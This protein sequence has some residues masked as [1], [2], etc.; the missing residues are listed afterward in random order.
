MAKHSVLKQVI[1][2]FFLL[3]FGA[4]C[5]I[6]QSSNSELMLFRKIIGA[7][8]LLNNENDSITAIDLI[9]NQDSI[10]LEMLMILNDTSNLNHLTI[11]I[12]SIQ[13]QSIVL[14]DT[15]LFNE[16]VFDF[17][18]TNNTLYFIKDLGKVINTHEL[19]CTVLIYNA[20]NQVT[21][22]INYTLWE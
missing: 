19:S 4:N 2:F 20:L 15:I 22:T 10:N 7:S 11:Q 16:I 1:V 21:D 13:N 12:G 9:S 6:A 8:N 14:I 5:S 17:N 18:S 3:M